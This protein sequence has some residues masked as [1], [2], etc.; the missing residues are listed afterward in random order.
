MGKLAINGGKPV[1]KNLGKKV[2]WPI[3]NKEDI[4][5][6]TDSL[7]SRKWCRI[8]PGSC[9]EKFENAFAR[10]HNAKYAIATANG[11][12]SLQLALRACGVRSGDEVIVPALTFIATA[13]A[14]TEIGAIPVF[15]DS[16]PDTL[17]ISAETI[18]NAITTRT[19]AVIGVHYGGYPI[20][21]DAIIPVVR[22]H[23]LVLIEDAAH[24]HGTEWKGRKIGAIG[25][26][27]SFSFQETKS[28][29][30]GEGGIIIT[31][32][33]RIAEEARLIH[34][35]GRV[36]GRP[37][38]EH[39]ISSSNYRLS[40]I[41]GALLLSQIRYLNSQT[42]HKHRMGEF[43]RKELNKLGIET[44][45]K[46]PRVTKRGYYFFVMRYKEERFKGVSRDKF[47]AAL[48]AEGVPVSNGYGMPLYKQPAF[49]RE[50]IRKVVN[51]RYLS[52]PDY[53]NLFLPVVEEFCREQLTLL[54][55]YLLL[56]K[57]EVQGIIDAFSKVIENI[58]E[59]K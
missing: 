45:K 37:G 46:D 12:V 7:R 1:I 27:G 35:I 50:T 39:Y 17:A 40:E 20:D 44:L 51:E 28:L 34:N 29:T 3:L 10:F 22:R 33:S 55:Y 52:I 26:I 47:M 16:D 6:V 19:R 9:V 41:Q 59:L 14:V 31:D 13:S 21:F 53:E 48:Q 4:K 11:T 43:L 25:D 30:A 5:A 2:I 23:S 49:R 36:L 42:Y 15:V 24:A 57:K 32:N 56:E 18:K 54:H 38:Y 8:Y 58:D